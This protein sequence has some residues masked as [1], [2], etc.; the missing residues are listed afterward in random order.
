MNEN[1]SSFICML[2]I[3]YFS[4]DI[5]LINDLE[6]AAQEEYDKCDQ[7]MS[8]SECL[9]VVKE[10][11]D[12]AKAYHVRMTKCIAAVPNLLDYRFDQ[13]DED[14]HFPL[15]DSMSQHLFHEKDDELET[16]MNA[17][18]KQEGIT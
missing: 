14:I 6:E 2:I 16:I 5:E 17:F 8:M 1:M 11:N 7:E 13:I 4:S 3:E 12:T 10:K 15:W 18:D 9:E